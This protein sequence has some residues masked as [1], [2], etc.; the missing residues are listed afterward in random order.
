MVRQIRYCQVAEI[1]KEHGIQGAQIAFT[2]NGE[3]EFQH[4]GIASAATNVPVTSSTIFEAASLTKVVGA[5][6]VLRLMERGVLALDAPLSMYV[7]SP[8]LAEDSP[9]RRV[10]A[11][12]V[13]NHTTGFPDWAISPSSP[14]LDTTPLTTSFEPGTKWS[15]SGEGFYF[16]QKAIEAI[17]DRPFSEVLSEEVFEPFEMHSSSLVTRPES[18]TVTAVG[19]QADGTALPAS[20]YTNANV[21]YTL[22]TTAQD[23]STFIQR[24]LLDGEGLTTA[25]H[26]LMFTASGSAN[27]EA[28]PSSAD[29]YVQ[30]GLGIGI[31]YNEKGTAVWHWGDNGAF[32]AFFIAFP[33]RAESVVVFTNNQNGLLSFEQI[34]KTFLGEQTFHSIRWVLS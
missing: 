32:K 17:L 31:Q 1:L 8:R 20:N 29:P 7:D 4:H 27:R 11:R 18:D 14:A 23:Y 26:N 15:Y 24:A 6:T 25:S 19:H 28:H 9:G 10:T 30:W 22:L 13:L 5:Y 3:T 16:L 2:R 34:M 33:D 21:A 12:M